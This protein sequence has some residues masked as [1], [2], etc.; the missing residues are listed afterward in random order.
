M[1]KKYGGI[2]HLG[3]LLVY[4]YIF[5]IF[6]PVLSFITSPGRDAV[7]IFRLFASFLYYGS[8]QD[9]FL[10]IIGNLG[11]FMIISSYQ[12]F[13]N[14]HVNKRYFSLIIGFFIVVPLLF[15]ILVSPYSSDSFSKPFAIPP[16]YWLYNFIH[17]GFL[18]LIQI[19]FSIFESLYRRKSTL[20][21]HQTH[22]IRYE[23]PHCHAT[24][25]ARIKYCPHC[26]KEISANPLTLDLP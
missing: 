21:I 7:I 8:S 24:F 20:I 5:G 6:Y 16:R 14:H 13:K 15:F 10:L 9:F 17:V 22:L 2:V 18:F 11:I 26:K 23:C 4:L 1:L 19:V 3:G 25:E 12:F